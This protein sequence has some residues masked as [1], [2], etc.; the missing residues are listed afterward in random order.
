MSDSL[1]NVACQSVV[2][3]FLL[4]LAF[5]AGLFWPIYTESS[6]STLHVMSPVQSVS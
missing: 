5:Q 4:F 3:I 1:I 2:I 6:C